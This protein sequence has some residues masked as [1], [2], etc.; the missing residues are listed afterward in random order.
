MQLPSVDRYLETLPKGAASYPECCVKAS[1]LLSMLAAKP[2]RTDV[3]LPSA[4]LA[5]VD[6]PPALTEWIPEV[7]F[8]AV[9]LWVW[10]VH[11]GG[12][13]LE[14]YRAWSLDHNRRLLGA[15]LYSVLFLVLSPDRLLNGMNNRWSAFRR[16][17]E[18][19]IAG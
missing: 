1:V 3:A 5:L 18:L 2:L 10:E 15:P 14:S 7:H 16:G 8:N 4:L 6:N 9:V 12:R 13:D 19:Q 17:T 11:F